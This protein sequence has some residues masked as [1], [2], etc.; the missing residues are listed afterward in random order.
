MK[1]VIDKIVADFMAST[2]AFP[3][4][5]HGCAGSLR[6]GEPAID[7]PARCRRPAEHSQARHLYDQRRRRFERE[8]LTHFALHRLAL[9]T[10]S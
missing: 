9:A 10:S 1:S 2:A 5:P 4:V 8:H 3:N 6:A 7:G